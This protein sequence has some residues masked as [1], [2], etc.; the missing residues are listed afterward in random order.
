M[1]NNRDKEKAQMLALTAVGCIGPVRMK[2]ILAEAETLD[3]VMAWDIPRWCRVPGISEQLAFR[4]VDKLDLTYGEQVLDWSRQNNYAI[5]TLLDDDYPPMLR[6]LYDPPPFLFV[7]GNLV[8]ADVKAV[9]IVGS[10]SATEYGRMT[11]SRLAGELARQGITVVSGMAIGVDSS[12]HRGAMAA[13]GRTIAVLGSGIDVIYPP[14]NKNLYQEIAEHGAILSEFFPGVE[15]NA[16]HFPRRNRIIA[17][18]ARAVVVVEAGQ[19]SGALLTADLALSQDKALFAVPGQLTSK[20]S[21]GTHDLIRAGAR[22]LVSADDIFS[23][24]PE[25][26]N[27]YIPAERAAP[28]ELSDQ[29]QRIFGLLSESPKQIDILVRDCGLTISEVSTCL[30]TLELR[31]LIKQLPGKRFIA[32]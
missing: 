24:L 26:K 29:E 4:I 25:L 13:G 27:D 19:K 12:S 11:A 21:Q 23:V 20:M 15:P 32:A 10:R 17:G 6:E 2:M 22:L 28:N 18:L 8:P 3:E 5:L 30:L 1:K 7:K 16:G 9:S 31:G 14:D